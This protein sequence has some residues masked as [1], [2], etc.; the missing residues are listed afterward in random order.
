MDK[1]PRLHVSVSELRSMQTCG[2]KWYYDYELRRKMPGT[3]QAVRGKAVHMVARD[4]LAAKRDGWTPMT[5]ENAADAAAAAFEASVAGE[6]VRFTNRDTREG[7][8]KVLGA[9]KDTAVRAA[10]LH[11]RAVVPRIT[12]VLL[13]ADVTT[14]APLAELGGK[15]LRGRIDVV[16]GVKFGRHRWTSFV[17]RDLK[18]SARTPP[19]AAIEGDQQLS[20]YALLYKMLT[21]TLPAL[22]A[23]DTLV[24]KKE[25][26]V[27]THTATR[28]EPQL[29]ATLEALAR[30]E[31]IRMAGIIP[32]PAQPDSWVCSQK[33]CGHTDYCPF[34]VKGADPNA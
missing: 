14:E 7:R 11:V 31:R 17:V 13:E 8:D 1:G 5:E 10:Q 22:V 4:A 9:E 3:P 24:M 29:E 16:D 34:Y 32:P 27:V 30:V 18:T 23:K 26:E 15:H 21:G 33:W 19:A 2:Q 28:E 6:G 20:V 12:P 25:P